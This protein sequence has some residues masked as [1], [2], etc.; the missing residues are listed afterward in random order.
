MVVTS[1]EFH[2]LGKAECRTLGMPDLR[3][4][5][6]PHPFGSLKRVLVKNHATKAWEQVEA[7]LTKQTI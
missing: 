7:G 6:V 2:T 5:I 3:F 1:K 4:A